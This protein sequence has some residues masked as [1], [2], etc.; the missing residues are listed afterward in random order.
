MTMEL[1]F[2]I[3]TGS[4]TH[5]FAMKNATTRNNIK[6]ICHGVVTK[7]MPENTTA[8][9]ILPTMMEPKLNALILDNV[10]AIQTVST[11][12]TSQFTV[13]TVDAL[14]VNSAIMTTEM[15]ALAKPA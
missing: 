12:K 8:R 4:T 13:I 7:M 1:A 6:C 14:T 15:M 5:A 3:G 10:S 11:S 2:A 9:T